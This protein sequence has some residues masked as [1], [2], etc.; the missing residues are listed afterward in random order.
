MGG[1]TWLVSKVIESPKMVFV[2]VS[3]HSSPLVN[4][5]RSSVRC[6]GAVAIG[7]LG[8]IAIGFAGAKIMN[9]AIPMLMVMV[10]AAVL[11]VVYGES[12]YMNAAAIAIVLSCGQRGVQTI[13]VGTTPLPTSWFAS[14][15][16]E[17]ERKKRALALWEG[18][19]CGPPLSLPD[20]LSPLARAARL[21][22]RATY[23][24]R[25]RGKCPFDLT[26]LRPCW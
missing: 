12:V 22:S 14:L 26:L 3:S 15:S 19:W 1:I 20:P 9:W 16:S 2:T 25:A 24:E 7:C 6:R 23:F 4:N 8:R 17:S 18:T 5:T 21:A 11:G 13:L 10:C